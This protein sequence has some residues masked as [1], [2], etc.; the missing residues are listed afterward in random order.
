M[1]KGDSFT[2][3]IQLRVDEGF[4]RGIDDWLTTHGHDWSRSEAIRHLVKE[5]IRSDRDIQDNVLPLLN[6]AQSA[7]RPNREFFEPDDRHA[8]VFNCLHLL[9]ELEEVE[10]LLQASEEKNLNIKKK[11]AEAREDVLGKIIEVYPAM[12]REELRRRSL[13]D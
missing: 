11:I 6:K 1:A 2:K 7:C 3:S 9:A 12:E 4:L 13:E 8:F 10:G 5:G